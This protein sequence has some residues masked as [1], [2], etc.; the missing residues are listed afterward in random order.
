MVHERQRDVTPSWHP[1]CRRPFWACSR[2]DRRH[3]GRLESVQD[4]LLKLALQIARDDSEVRRERQRQGVKLAK[5]A[6]KYRGRPADELA[7]R[8]IIVFRNT[9]RSIS[10]TAR[11]AGCSESLIKR[12][13]VGHQYSDS[14]DSIIAV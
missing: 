11:L 12:V 3:L 2:H 8:R 9:G 10:G 6:G 5:H 13:R 7:H 14:A 4:T 1:W